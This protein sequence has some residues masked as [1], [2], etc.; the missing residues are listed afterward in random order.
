MVVSRINS[1]KRRAIVSWRKSDT[2]TLRLRHDGFAHAR[3][4]AIR[5]TNPLVRTLTGSSELSVG[6]WVLVGGCG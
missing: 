3:E 2:S 5:S 6:E 4:P 1:V